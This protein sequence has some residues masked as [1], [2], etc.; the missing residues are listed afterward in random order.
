MSTRVTP[1]VDKRRAV[2]AASFTPEKAS[3]KQRDSLHS[4]ESHHV[5]IAHTDDSNRLL[6]W[7]S[8]DA[9][10][11]P[12]EGI[13]RDFDMNMQY[14]PCCSI[15]RED[16]WIRAKSLGLNPPDALLDLIH[17]SSCRESVLDQHLSQIAASQFI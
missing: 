13:L 4:S 12:Q 9:A 1:R 7:D 6:S 8:S 14:G 2:S 11:M 3:S 5:K 17:Q 16:R 10:P 15:S